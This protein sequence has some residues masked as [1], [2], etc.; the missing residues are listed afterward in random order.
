MIAARPHPINTHGIGLIASLWRSGMDTWEIFLDMNRR[1][2]AVTEAQVLAVI[3][4]ERHARR[5]AAI[6]PCDTEEAR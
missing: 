3:H 6:R 5:Q 2:Y 1:G 4:A